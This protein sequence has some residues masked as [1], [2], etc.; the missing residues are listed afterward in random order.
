[1][2]IFDLCF[3][4][5]S[6]KGYVELSVGG[7]TRQHRKWL[8]LAVDQA[9]TF[10]DS[11]EGQNNVYF[12]PAIR[13]A[14][15]KMGK[16]NC[17]S[18]QVCWV[19][20]D[21]VERPV[22][23]L[24]PSVF[25]WSGHGWHLYWKLGSTST[26]LI[27]VEQANKALASSLGESG[28]HNID[29]LLRVPGTINAKDT[30]HPTPCRLVSSAPNVYTLS[31]LVL[32][33]LLP[34]K[35]I[36]KIITG[37]AR[38]YPSRS[39]RDWAIIKAL[40]IAGFTDGDIRKIFEAHP[41]GDKFRDPGEGGPSYL[42]HTIKSVR[43][44]HTPTTP[45]NTFI[46][47]DNCYHIKL[48]G[49]TRQV[50]TFVLTPTLLLEGDQDSIVSDVRAST[51]PNQVHRDV[52][53]P[54]SAFS[55][56]T[57][58]SRKLPKASWVWL[59]SDGDVR[60]L[61]AYLSAQMEHH[62]IPKAIATSIIGRHPAGRPGSANP[63]GPA[64]STSSANP[65]EY[66]VADSY[67]LA[68]DGTIW[69]TPREAPIMYVES[70]REAPHLTH[71]PPPESQD[72]ELLAYLLPA[73]NTPTR[74]WPMLGWF[75]AA[76]MKPVLARFGYR[77]PILNICG[78]RGS[79][80]TSLIL[81]VFQ[82]LLGY[83]DPCSY[84]VGTT[85]FV[86]LSLLSSTNAIPIA[87]SEFR[88][89]IS[90]G[91]AK[92]V[93]LSYDVG[94]DA[95]GRPD[96]TTV[97]YPLIAPFTVDGEDKLDDP[98]MLERA[99]VVMLSPQTILEGEPAWEAF[100]LLPRLDLTSFGVPYLQHTLMADV[101][102]LLDVAEQAIREAFPERLPDRIRRNLTV[103]WLGVLTFS[104]FML[105]N[106]VHCAP[107]S[108]RAALSESLGNV[109]STKLKRAPVAADPFVEY[110]VNM[111][112]RSTRFFPWALEDKIL[113]FQCAPA[114]EGYVSQ[115]ARQGQNTLSKNAMIGQL[116]ELRS[117]Y[118]TDVTVRQLKGRKVLAFGVSLEL[119]HAAGL[120]IPESFSTSTFTFTV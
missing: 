91:F 28:T 87:F 55:R 33:P 92:Y 19:D 112:A 26:N 81:E 100:Q 93:R 16:D 13:E 97:E 71:G 45:A 76:P 56:V 60:S 42:A 68:S 48:K 65:I 4:N 53:F 49:G 114:Y 14:P 64:S 86:T 23:I 106:G 34:N 90:P 31:S 117:D 5:S 47:K 77:F 99:I 96:Q 1:M 82:A 18:S 54:R 62:K 22:P 104:Q 24:P 94:K 25:V 75:M 58:F 78:T 21:R 66:F 11:S 73:L 30:N 84:D 35:I 40:V 10:L 41:C 80:K 105:A 70:G 116:Y 36:R 7:T 2:L 8:S 119:A 15:G 74:I 17:L 69:D 102:I 103:C 29:R 51:A 61:L 59:G 50:S 46:E 98:A 12:G 57:T 20:Y 109:Y 107:G 83:K 120:D 115:K 27:R 85:R 95:R 118:I 43:K 89:A 38:G 9:A 113:W 79:G 63:S 108:A 88:A 111:A 37:D 110:V 39:E 72:F 44:Q 6:P 32:P 3:D 67:V 101:G 52:V